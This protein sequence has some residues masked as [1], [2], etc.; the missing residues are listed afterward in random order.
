MTSRSGYMTYVSYTA[1]SDKGNVKR[2]N[3]LN[4][5]W[6]LKQENNED[7]QYTSSKVNLSGKVPE[8]EEDDKGNKTQVIPLRWTPVR[9]GTIKL[10]I[11]GKTYYDTYGDGNLYYYDGVQPT[12]TEILEPNG[13]I[14]VKVDGGDATPTKEA[15]FKVKYGTT[16]DGNF[17]RD[18]LP[19]SIV[20]DDDT[21]LTGDYSL[22]YVYDNTYIPQNDIPLLNAKLDA[23]TL[24]AKARRIAVYYS[25]IDQYI[26]KTDY[27]WDLGESLATQ[28]VGQ[29]QYEIDTEVVKTIDDA[30]GAAQI[31]WNRAIP[32]GISKAEHYQGFSEVISIGSQIIY[33]RTKRFTANWMIVASDVLPVIAMIQGWKAA[34][35]GQMN[36]PYFAGELNGIKVFVSPAIAAGRFL[37]GVLGNDMMSAVAVYAPY[38]TIL[39]T[40]LLNYADSSLSQGFCTMYDIEVLNANLVVAGKMEGMANT[41]MY[42]T[43][44]NPFIT[45]VAD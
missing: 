13:K 15:K 20:Y 6:G 39:P 17:N 14:I 33:D 25:Q 21:A 35:A 29:L 42:A 12:V 37:I 5:V 40:S 43:Q 45:K 8:Q 26:A 28:A 31:S 9:G 10:T 27:G 19:G 11:D 41:F 23:I 44:A 22:S 32:V 24:Q 2:G 36:G 38:M 16:R 7:A 1:G 3:V 34:P 30:A 4:D 18:E